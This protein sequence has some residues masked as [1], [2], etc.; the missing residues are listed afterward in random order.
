MI[1]AKQAIYIAKQKA[2]DVLEQAASNV[3]EIERQ[4]YDGH[5]VWSITLSFPRDPRQLGP[6][7]RFSADPFQYKRF[8]IDIETEELLAVKM[9]EV[10]SQ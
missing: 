7:A 8:L 2:A 10:A 3:E 9:R 6:Y 4:V 5:D 1:D